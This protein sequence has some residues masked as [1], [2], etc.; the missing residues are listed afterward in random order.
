MSQI[1]KTLTSS[2]PIPPIIPTSFETQDGD[3]VPLANVLIIDAF[4]STEDNDNGITTKGGTDAGNPP[5]TGAT[6]EVSI[7]LTNRIQGNIV[8]NDAVATT[9]ITFPMTAAGTYIF[10]VKIAAFNSTSTLG[11]GYNIFGTAR[12]NGTDSF[13]VGTPDKIMNEE[14]A[15]SACNVALVVG[16]LG[17]VNALIQVTGYGAETIEW[18]AVGYYCTIS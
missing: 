11:A 16:G 13:L 8:T 5:G 12:S 6:N 7:Y 17:S 9:I 3:A 18:C 1:Y 2:G 14:G 15:M 10:E 4:D